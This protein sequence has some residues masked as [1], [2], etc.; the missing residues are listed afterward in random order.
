MDRLVATRTP[1]SKTISAIG[2]IGNSREI[3]VRVGNADG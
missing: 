2:F 1:S 3:G